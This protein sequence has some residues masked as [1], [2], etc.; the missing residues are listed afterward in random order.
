MGLL[1]SLDHLLLRAADVDALVEAYRDALDA[2]VVG[3]AGAGRVRMR[4]ANI[5][6]VIEPGVPSGEVVAAFRIQDAE[7]FRAHLGRTAFELERV[8]EVPGAVVLAYRD[9]AGNRLQAVRW[10]GRIEDLVADGVREGQPS[11]PR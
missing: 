10:G 7:A 6:V 11:A 1:G 3:E 4:L 9:P 8:E 5:D 2:V